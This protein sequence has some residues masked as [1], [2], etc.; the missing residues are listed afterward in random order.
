M[1]GSGGIARSQREANQPEYDAEGKLPTYCLQRTRRLGR[2][3]SGC[4]GW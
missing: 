1:F 2:G 3:L 4:S